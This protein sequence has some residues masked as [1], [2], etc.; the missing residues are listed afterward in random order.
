[1]KYKLIALDLDNTL[2]DMEHKLS[3]NTIKTIQSIQQRGYE[4]IIATG[5]MFI[6]TLPFAQK[7][8]LENEVISYNGA[9]IMDVVSKE[10]IFQQSIEL[11]TAREIINICNEVDLHLNIYL[12]DQLFVGEYNHLVKKYEK[13]AGIKARVVGNLHQFLK[14]DPTKL[15]VIENNREKKKKFLQMFKRKFKNKL[16]VTES[17]AKFIEF[18]APGVSKGKALRFLVDKKGVKQSQVIAAGDGWNDAEM[19]EWAGLGI[20]MG[21]APEEIKDKADLVAPHHDREGVARI[22]SRI[23]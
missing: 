3:E 15:L 14:K 1:M 16:A 2:L 20:A 6:S 17:K 7:L 4:I 21:N 5:R 18:M 13:I 8:N 11:D 9:L 22:L 10:K 19:I 23:L 12:D